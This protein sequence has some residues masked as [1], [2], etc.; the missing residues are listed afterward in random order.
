MEI[1]NFKIQNWKNFQNAECLFHKRAFFIGPNASGKSN[2]LDAIR[3]LRDLCAV[4]GGGLQAAVVHRGGLSAIRCLSARRTPE[5]SF[6]VSLDDQKGRIWRYFL[7]FSST[8]KA[9][10]QRAIIKT[11]RVDRYENNDQK[12]LLDRP[13]K[14]DAADHER[15]T[16][17]AIEQTSRNKDFREIASYFRTVKYLHVVPQVIR[18]PARHIDDPHDPFGG[19]LL[20]KINET[21]DKTRNARLKRMN[22]ALQIAVPQMQE[23]DLEVD[24]RGVP[25]LKAKY[26]HWRPRGA[27]QREDQFSDGTLRL[28]GLIWSLL[29]KGGPLLLEEPELSLNP[30]VV[31]KLP[32]LML[33]AAHRSKRQTFITTHSPDLLSD[34]G[35]GLDEV[36]LLT[37]TD[38]G[39]SVTAGAEL[40]DVRAM[41]GAGLPLSEA[42]LPMT[43]GKN[44]EDLSQ[45]KLF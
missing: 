42:V 33:R 24:K 5:I 15:L 9:R 43:K 8:G 31:S 2:F 27:W 45:I 37:P 16:E 23:L 19:D 6:E 22:E 28:L 39:T 21:P 40:E 4:D 34:P 14:Y 3:F 1:R 20:Q 30:G 36:F 32:A 26:R 29:E 25:H 10:D 41:L 44:A 13:D 11:E 38:E 35:I 7:A 18:D 17:T 12:N